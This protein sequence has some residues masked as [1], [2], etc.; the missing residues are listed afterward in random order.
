MRTQGTFS[1][2]DTQRYYGAQSA[3]FPSNYRYILVFV[4]DFSRLAK[5][6]SQ[7]NKS[8]SGDGLENYLKTTK[9]MVYRAV[10]DKLEAA[11]DA[12]YKDLENSATTSGFIV[13]LFFGDPISWKRHKQNI[14]NLLTC[15]AEYLAMSEISACQELISLD[16]AIRDMTGTTFYPTTVWCDNLSAVNC[17]QMERFH[18]LNYFDKTLDVIRDDLK[19]RE[20]KRN[21]R[22]LSETHGDF[23]KFCAKEGFIRVKWVSTKEN[24]VD[25]FTEPLPLIIHSKFTHVILNINREN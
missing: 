21:K 22:P 20:K 14:I 4:D 18:K 25:I 15:G 19:F 13:K 9:N 6:F 12:S 17:T 1:G 2:A 24:E 8:D 5:I 10:G 16:K 7:K 23:V 11:T 3:S